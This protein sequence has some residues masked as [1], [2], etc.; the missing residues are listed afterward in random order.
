[1][2]N[3]V[4]APQ[5]TTPNRDTPKR[6][7]LPGETPTASDASV[8]YL[9]Q[10]SGTATEWQK[11]AWWRQEFRQGFRRVHDEVPKEQ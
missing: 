4:D 9:P 6:D 10:P 3:R 1:M 11:R 8:G 7:A 5:E 2:V